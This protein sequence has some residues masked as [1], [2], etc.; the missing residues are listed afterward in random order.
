VAD[1]LT[2]L[3]KNERARFEEYWEAYELVIK[4]GLLQDEK[5]APRAKELLIWKTSQ[6]KWKTTEELENGKKTIL[7]CEPEQEKSPLVT[8]YVAKGREVAVLSSP[9]DHPLMSRLER[10][11]SLT[12]RRV[13]AA[14]DEHL[15]DP[16]REKSVLDASGRTE[17]AKIADF[18][19]NAI[20]APTLTVE[21]KSLDLPS[22]PA[23]MTLE[24]EERRFRDYLTRVAGKSPSITPKACLVVNT[25]SPLVQ[26][27]FK[28]HTSQPKLAAMLA[29][30]IWDVTRLA[31]KELSPDELHAFTERSTRLLEELTVS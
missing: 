23:V 13:D 22:V 29:L 26:A 9:L 12:F 16:S 2:N 10:D 6:Q 1:A 18:F 31:H 17:S 30:H 19:R 11:G 4:L 7:Y 5:F 21:A 14:L 20:S 24:E 15:L 3:F 27:A 25:N 28:A 8:A